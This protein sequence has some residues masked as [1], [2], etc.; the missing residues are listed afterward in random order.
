MKKEIPPAAIIAAVVVVVAIV[1][2][3]AYKTFGGNPAAMTATADQV[4]QVKQMRG[5]VMQQGVHRDANGHFVDA[6]GKPVDLSLG[7]K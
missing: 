1:G 4:N 7:S 6:E 5:K 2:F 3:F